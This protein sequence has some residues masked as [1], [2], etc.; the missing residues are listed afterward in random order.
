M[1]VGILENYG[2][3]DALIRL[4]DVCC[5]MLRMFLRSSKHTA[6]QL[7]LHK[8]TQKALYW[9][10]SAH[11]KVAQIASLNLETTEGG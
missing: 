5:A 8:T 6:L 3:S 7:V 9:Q 2:G 11:Q 1:S 10:I 4:L